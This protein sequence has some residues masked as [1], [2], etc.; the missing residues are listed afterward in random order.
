M[1]NL[2]RRPVGTWCSNKRPHISSW[3]WS[4]ASGRRIV[5]PLRREKSNADDFLGNVRTTLLWNAIN[6]A[7]KEIDSA[8]QISYTDSPFSAFARHRPE[9]SSL[10]QSTE[11]ETRECLEYDR[12][13]TLL[14]TVQCFTTRFA[15]SNRYVHV[16]YACRQCPRPQYRQRVRTADSAPF[17]ETGRRSTVF[18]GIPKSGFTYSSLPNASLAFPGVPSGKASAL[19]FP[20]T[21][22][23]QFRGRLQ[24]SE[25]KSLH[26]SQRETPKR[27]SDNIFTVARSLIAQERSFAAET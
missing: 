27:S 6:G 25:P 5:R 11:G 1:V 4:M 24:T 17:C 21:G 10:V 16:L 20:N 23:I 2:K 8:N 14:E 22:S 3:Q 15:A 19:H 7:L 18:D 12:G 26:P 9:R 13:R